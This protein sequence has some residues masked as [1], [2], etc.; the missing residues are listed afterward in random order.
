[1]LKIG[2][3]KKHEEFLFCVLSY[4]CKTVLHK[5]VL[6]KTVKLFNDKT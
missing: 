2:H 3:L 5:T 4:F 1:M 6:H